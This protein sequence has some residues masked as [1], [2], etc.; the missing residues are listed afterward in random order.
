LINYD[1]GDVEATTPEM[2]RSLS[3]AGTQIVATGGGSFEVGARVSCNW[4]NGGTFYDG[5]V[6]E[7]RAAGRILIHYDDGDVEE[8]TPDK[9]RS[10]TPVAAGG[11]L[12]GTYAIVSSANPGGGAAY[13]GN[14]TITRSGE[15][16][17]LD[18][19][20]PG[21]PPYFGVGLE[22]S[23]WLAVGW[24]SGSSGVVVYRVS[25]G[26]LSGKWA[27]IGSG[28]TPGIEDLSGPAGVNGTYQIVRAQNPQGA[29]YT[30][31]VSIAPNGQTHTLSWTL[32]HESYAGVGILRGDVLAVGW[33]GGGTGVV[34]YKVNGRRLEGVWADPRGGSLGSEVL[35]RR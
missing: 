7:Q 6:A 4:K 27:S 25:G 17:R 11:G 2:C 16:Y 22:V 35:E 32:P 19:S 13:T 21:S 23:G 33:G 14:V 3:P 24:G 9:C 1:D 34:A 20:I 10:A 5:R 8:T 31:S 18:W 15:V 28:P 12:S 30:G 29:G 26:Q